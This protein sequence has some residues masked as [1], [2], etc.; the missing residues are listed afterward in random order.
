MDYS[1]CL[2]NSKSYEKY[3]YH[4]NFEKIFGKCKAP[5]VHPSH[6]FIN[7]HRRSPPLSPRAVS[8]VR[9]KRM[10]CNTYYATFTTPKT[11]PKVTEN[12][13]IPAHSK[14]H[15]IIA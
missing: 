7:P 10:S 3:S 12:T 6:K 11:R 14:L 5:F 8:A 13:A 15:P 2:R 1:H 4:S 9:R